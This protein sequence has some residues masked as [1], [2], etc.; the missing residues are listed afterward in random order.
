MKTLL[1]VGYWFNMRPGAIEGN[2]QLAF[3]FF[4]GTL[5]ALAFIF[6]L[7]KK[8]QKGIYTKIWSKLFSFS[9]INL[10][11]GLFLFFFTFELLPFLSMRIWFLIWLL[12]MVAWIGY[13][14]RMLLQIPKIKEENAKLKAFNKYIP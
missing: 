12:A 9:Y 4:L 1:T 8:R 13:I 2:F 14:V 3:V 11:I 6:W 10:I 7:L 5:F